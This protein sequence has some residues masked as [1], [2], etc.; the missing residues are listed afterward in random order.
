MLSGFAKLNHF[1]FKAKTARKT[2]ASM[3]GWP[4]EGL[5]DPYDGE[6]SRIKYELY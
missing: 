5:K 6:N 3:L 4:F 1:Y 2:D